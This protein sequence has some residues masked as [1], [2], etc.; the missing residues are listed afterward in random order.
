[1]FDHDPFPGSHPCSSPGCTNI[2]TYDDEPCCYTHSSDDG[3]FVK[4]YS[5]KA[6][7]ENQG[8]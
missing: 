6:S 1:M 4:G 8:L 3:S 7:R 2:V 5:Y